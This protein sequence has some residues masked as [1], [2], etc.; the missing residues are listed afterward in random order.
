MIRRRVP[1]WF[2]KA[3][4]RALRDR[5]VAFLALGRRYT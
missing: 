2:R 3:T 5:N 4:F 1:Q